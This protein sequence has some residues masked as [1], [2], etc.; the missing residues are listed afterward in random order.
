[1]RTLLLW[2]TSMLLTV[3][4]FAQYTDYLGAGQ[5]QGITFKSSDPNADGLKA[6]DGT[7]YEQE[8]QGAS[9]FLA[10]ATL[11]YT[12][13]DV[14]KVAEMGIPAWIEEQLDAPPSLYTDMVLEL[15]Q[16]WRANCVEVLD[17]QQ[18][19]QLFRNTP[20]QFRTAWWD[21][22]MKGADQLRQR[23]AMALSEI[24][25][26]SDQS[27]LQ[28][29]AQGLS[30][31]YD[32]L[33]RNA[34]GNYE[35][36]LNEVSINMA[37]GFYLTHLNNPPTDT[38]ANIRP[39]ENYAREI[40]QLFTIG[41]HELNND[42]SR[43]IGADGRWIPTYDNNDIKGLAKV[44]TGLGGSALSGVRP[45]AP[46]FGQ[47]YRQLSFTEPMRMYEQ[48][49]EPGEKHIIGGYTIPAGQTGMED[50]REA[51]NVLFNHPNVGPFLALRLIQRLVKSNPTPGY[52]DR[53][54]SVFNDNGSGERGD[55][56]AVVQAIL[57]DEEAYACYWINGFGNGMLRAPTLRYTQ[58][59]RG[60]KAEAPSEIFHNSG[61]SFK[62]FTDHF[63]LSAP[64]VFN[65]YTPDYSPDADFA[66]YEFVGPEYQILNS[67]TSSNYVN[68]ML[69]A[70]M[71]NYINRVDPNANLGNYLNGPNFRNFDRQR[72]QYEAE[73]TD[74]L[75]LSL[76]DRPNQLV[77]YLDLL[78]ANGA[79]SDDLK[80]RIVSSIQT[81]GLFTPAEAAHYALFLTMIDP[82]YVILK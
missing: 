42:G 53:V 79:M 35:D 28:F 47:D 49:H 20:A 38:I 3:A 40:M 19:R 52:I 31:F 72:R 25:V 12:I 67:S 45:G 9:R 54:A 2:M 5:A 18:C 65:F 48:Y 74:P 13:E 66:L 10:T 6:V 30:T 33:S 43:K 70:L 63:V 41:L 37:M 77:D 58:M 69:F 17:E 55:L 61:D 11:G 15:A 60:L 75:W 62:D 81:S 1:M 78:M 22:V 71:R 80:D 21:R 7:G 57:S 8:L 44:F 56:A 73:L 26:V 76:G 68:F 59:M 36:I 14:Q 32:I 34:F 46:R 4:C 27:N 51:I 16:V 64:T 24:I 82:D 50:I 23:V 39:D 29:F